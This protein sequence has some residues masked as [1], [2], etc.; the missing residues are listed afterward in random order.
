MIIDGFLV[1]SDAQQ[2]LASAASTDYIDTLAEG[3]AI[4]PGARLHVVVNTLF[5]TSD[6][7]TLTIALQTDAATTFDT[8]PTSLFTTSALGAAD[9]TAGDVLIARVVLDTAKTMD[10]NL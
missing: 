4:T 10:L 1:M 7:G 3:D 5:V 9:L 8:G 6:V 2:V